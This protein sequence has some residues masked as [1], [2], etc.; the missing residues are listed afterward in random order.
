MTHLAE[1]S[2][3][4]NAPHRPRPPPPAHHAWMTFWKTHRSPPCP[5]THILTHHASPSPRIQRCVTEPG[6][7]GAGGTR[8]GQQTSGVGLGGA[9]GAAAAGAPQPEEEG[10]GGEG[11]GWIRMLKSPSACPCGVLSLS[12]SPVALPLSLLRNFHHTT[13]GVELDVWHRYIPFG[14]GIPDAGAMVR[15]DIVFLGEGI[16]L[17]NGT[18]RK[19]LGWFCQSRS[20]RGL[21]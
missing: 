21:G 15:I 8:G 3:P 6:R 1:L 7:R 2:I 4:H 10:D 20:S 5:P 9:G 12:R 11:V 18:A 16:Q 13:R 14:I 17:R 19:R